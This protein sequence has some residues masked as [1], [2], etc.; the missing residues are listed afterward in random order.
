MVS[1]K[2]SLD[3]RAIDSKN[4]IIKAYTKLLSQKD[5]DYISI[6]ELCELSHIN[7]TTFYRHYKSLSDIEADI[8]N[9]VLEKINELFLKAN[10]QD[11]MTGREQFL[12]DVYKLI[13]SDIEFYS[14]IL[15]SNQKIGLLERIIRVV[16]DRLRTTMTAKTSISPAQID[17]ILTF[18][19]AGR[20][21]VY[22]KW[23]LDGYMPPEEVVSETL[24][25]ISASGFD[26]FLTGK[27]D[28]ESEF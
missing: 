19:I 5:R 25:K 21:A 27:C 2:D 15:L 11:Y 14:M 28:E 4:K 23:I 10:F 3:P 8:E 12:G 9:T 22:R 24:S 1:C 26:K 20:I 18:V 13:T 17:L 6:N 7:R 16:R